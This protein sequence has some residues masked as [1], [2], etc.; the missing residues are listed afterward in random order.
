MILNIFLAGRWVMEAGG[1]EN[2]PNDSVIKLPASN[3]W[4]PFLIYQ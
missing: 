3:L 4:L 1:N 2:H